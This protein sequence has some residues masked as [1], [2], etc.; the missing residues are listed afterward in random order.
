MLSWHKWVIK[1]KQAFSLTL[2]ENTPTVS[3]SLW[4]C[5]SKP[6][7]SRLRLDRLQVLLWLCPAGSHS[8]WINY[9]KNEDGRPTTTTM[10]AVAPEPTSHPHEGPGAQKDLLSPPPTSVGLWAFVSPHTCWDFGPLRE[11]YDFRAGKNHVILHGWS[12]SRK[13]PADSRIAFRPTVTACTNAY[14]IYTI[15]TLSL[16]VLVYV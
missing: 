2:A 11:K 16:S 5:C 1:P 4:P 8:V 13:P 10:M 15:Y 7:P 6:A 14:N 3:C 12:F 9:L